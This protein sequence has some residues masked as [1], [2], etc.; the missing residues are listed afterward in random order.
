MGYRQFADPIMI[1]TVGGSTTQLCATLT[2]M[3]DLIYDTMVKQQMSSLNVILKI[4][5][6]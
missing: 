2:S 1:Q 3:S 6:I 4:H 5:E